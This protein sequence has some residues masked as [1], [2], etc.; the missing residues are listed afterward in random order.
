MERTD[1][2]YAVATPGLEQPHAAVTA[3]VPESTQPAGLVSDQ[4]HRRTTGLKRQ[5]VARLNERLC[6]SC[7]DPTAPESQPHLFVEDL[8]GTVE[9]RWQRLGLLNRP[10]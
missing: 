4:H 9:H 6:P 10:E 7:T 5:V 3:A 8:R 2:P 1:N